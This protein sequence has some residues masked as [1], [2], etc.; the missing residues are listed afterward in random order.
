MN[1]Y[2]SIQSSTYVG[3]VLLLTPIFSLDVRYPPQAAQQVH[4]LTPQVATPVLPA[5]QRSWGPPVP[6]STVWVKM[7][8]AWFHI[9]IAGTVHI[10]P[11]KYKGGC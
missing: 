5:S 11:T 6:P 2:I 3:N 9:N 7:M 8:E 10:H 4:P 1:I